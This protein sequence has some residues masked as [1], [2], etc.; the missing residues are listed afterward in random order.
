V[1]EEPVAVLE[2]VEAEVLEPEV[3]TAPAAVVSRSQRK[4]L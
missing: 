4:A 3:V 1:V 2:V